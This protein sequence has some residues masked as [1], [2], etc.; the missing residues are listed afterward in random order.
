MIKLATKFKNDKSNCKQNFS[1]FKFD[2]GG[3]DFPEGIKIPES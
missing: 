2:K 3:Q 1:N